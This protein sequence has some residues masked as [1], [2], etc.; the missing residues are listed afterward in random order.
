[1]G[2]K[3]IF[4]FL[5]YNILLVVQIKDFKQ[6]RLNEKK[7]KLKYLFILCLVGFMHLSVFAQNF[8]VSGTVLNKNSHQPVQNVNIQV[9]PNNKFGYITNKDGKFLLEAGKG[10][11]TLKFSHISFKTKIVILNEKSASDTNLLVLLTPKSYTLDEVLINDKRYQTIYKKHKQSV[12][13]YA[14]YKDR[15]FFLVNDYSDGKTKMFSVSSTLT[16]TIFINPP[17]KPKKLII[18]F[19]HNL[20]LVSKSDSAYQILIDNNHINFLKPFSFEKLSKLKELYDF[21]IGS[22]Y[23]YSDFETVIKDKINYGYVD[24]LDKKEIVFYSI[25]D[26]DKVDYFYDVLKFK[27]SNTFRVL[28]IP[29]GEKRREYVTKHYNSGDLY[30]DEIWF[31]NNISNI[32]FNINNDVYIIDNVNNKLLLFDKNGNRIAR[33]SITCDSSDNKTCQLLQTEGGRIWKNKVVVDF[34]NTKRVYFLW[35][36]GVKTELYSLTLNTGKITYLKTMPHIFPKKITVYRNK[37]Y[38]LYQ[39]PGNL[40]NFGLYRAAL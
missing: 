20:E 1:M 3:K 10:I 5:V 13:D 25:F 16:D 14:L 31:Y 32:F 26:D 30:L 18:D 15:I 28:I 21:K 19:Y 2:L 39:Q 24:T 8:F 11:V 35:K 9:L 6:V 38:Y 7:V 17:C 12:I 27:R 40:R 22:R 33:V 23:Y 4:T 29:P 34:Y 36:Q 37:V